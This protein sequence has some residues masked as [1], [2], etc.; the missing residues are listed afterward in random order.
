[1]A[2]LMGNE[3]YWQQQWGDRRAPHVA[4]I[5]AFIDG[6]MASPGRTGVPYVAP[7]Y[8]GVNARVLFVA[9]D[10]GPKTQRDHGGSGFLSLENDDPSAER[11][12][13]L[14]NGAGIPVDETLPWNAYPWYINHQP[15]AAQLDDGV[16]PLHRLLGLLP[17]LRVVVLH[18]GSA[19]DGW[20]RLKRRYP[21]LADG[22]EVVETYHTSN[23]AFIGPPEVRAARMAKLTRD[24]ARIAQ[25][26]HDPQ[27]ATIADLLRR[28]NEIDAAIAKII[29]R[30]MASG[31]LGEWIAAQVFNIALEKAA[32]VPAIDGRFR[33][34]PLMGKTVNVKWYLKEE[35]LLDMTESEALD[36]YL[37]M[38][39]PH[40]PALSSRHSVR[41][42]HIDSVYLFDAADLLA[43]LRDHNLKIGIASSVSQSLWKAAEIYPEPRNSLLPLT[44]A[45]MSLLRLFASP[46]G[47]GV[48]GNSPTG[49]S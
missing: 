23:Q 33:S 22:L 7:V 17:R 37:V 3:A 31:H 41:P 16:E 43:R 34:G 2:R 20:K 15:N 19:Q 8:G 36:F 24:F 47:S 13:A 29:G 28:R 40:S 38:T 49:K 30:P 12:A 10:P 48:G 32:T 18:G 42:W 25:I 21:G 6:L 46:A 4:P 1:M 9:R 45:Q 44:S 27:L 11:F 39:G 5:N 14:L 35:G 26:L